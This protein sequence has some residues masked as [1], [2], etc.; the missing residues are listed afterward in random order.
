MGSNRD[1]SIFETG[2]LFKHITSGTFTA[3]LGGS[4]LEQLI[5]MFYA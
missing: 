2:L 1:Y 3:E 5:N 4:L